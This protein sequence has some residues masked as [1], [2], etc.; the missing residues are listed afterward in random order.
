MLV[1]IIFTYS[2]GAALAV[3]ALLPLQ[4]ALRYL[5]FKHVIAVVCVGVL[6]LVLFPQYGSR[7]AS[8]GTVGGATAQ[9]GSSNAADLSIQQRATENLAAWLAVQ[10]HPLL[11]LGSGEFPPRVS[12]LREQG[13][14]RDSRCE[15]ARRSLRAV[16]GT[17]A[18]AC[19]AEHLVV[20]SRGSGHDGLGGIHL[21]P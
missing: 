10:D 19:R 9:V 8:L 7:I 11:G 1:A 13:R 4:M 15:Q 3:V 5:R 12:V 17:S 2:R 6:L 16:R 20:R 14:R 18:S 21:S